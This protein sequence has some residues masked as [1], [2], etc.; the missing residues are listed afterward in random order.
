MHYITGTS[1]SVKPDPKR[2]YKSKE[3]V[4]SVNTL[5]RLATI[6]SCETGLQYTFIGVDKTNIDIQFSS[7]R[8]ADLFIAKMRNEMLPDYDARYASRSDDI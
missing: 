1:F 2:G 8:E 6:K 7:S 3:N 5:Y 4:F